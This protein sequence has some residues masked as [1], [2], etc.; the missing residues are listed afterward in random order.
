MLLFGVVEFA[1]AGPIIQI[2]GRKEPEVI[3]IATTALRFQCLTFPTLGLSTLTTMLL[4]NLGLTTSASI[5]SSGRQGLFLAP[6]IVLT[7]ALWGIFGVEI[8][9][10]IADLIAFAVA[11][12]CAWKALK[13]LDILNNR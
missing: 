9:Q 8:A 1:L 11:A 7:S 2:F 3:A 13:N 4:Q 10:P 12:P 5:L 6:V